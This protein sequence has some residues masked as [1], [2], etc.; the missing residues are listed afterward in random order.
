MKK[1]LLSLLAACSVVHAGS[2]EV[3]A[4]YA[5]IVVS[6]YSDSLKTAIELQREVDALISDPSEA[7][8]AAARQAWLYARVAYGQ[9]EVFRFYGGPIDFADEKTGEE[10]P[11]GQLNAWPLNEAYI[12]YVV[13]NEKAGIVQDLSVTISKEML[14]EKNGA[15][16]ETDV[17]TGYHAIEFLLW[18]QDLSL[19]GPGARPASDYALGSEINARRATYLKIVTDL[20]VEDLSGLV[21]A[22]KEDAYKKDFLAQD[23]NKTLS[24]VMS[25]MATL[26]A[27]EMGSER[28]ATAIDSGDQEDEHSCFS[29][30]THHDFIYNQLGIRNVFYGR[31]KTFQGESIADLLAAK[32]AKLKSDIDQTLNDLDLALAEISVP[33]D[34][35]LSMKKDSKEKK[36]LEECV[37]LLQKQAELFVEAGKALNIEV[38]IAAE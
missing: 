8:L 30:N 11:E 27:F 33:V 24:E 25:A 35:A 7:R 14:I 3:V 9:S 6:T 17:T 5:K 12:D 34:K 32:D 36:Q 38:T 16:D 2:K 15:E 21:D 19:E 22:W 20:L 31:Y 37:A 18:G 26:S 4:D 13:G 23:T 28:L 1:T 29:D 10:G